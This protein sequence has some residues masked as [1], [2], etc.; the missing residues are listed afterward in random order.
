MVFVSITNININEGG[1]RML[2]LLPRS[3][4]T[5]PYHTMDR[6]NKRERRP[7]SGVGRILSCL[8]DSMSGADE[9]P[10]M[11]F[12]NSVVCGSEA[13][14]RLANTI[15]DDA[16]VFSGRRTIDAGKRVGLSEKTTTRLWRSGEQRCNMSSQG[17]AIET[18]RT[19]LN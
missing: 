16:A 17:V 19:K 14:S 9:Y 13:S 1:V 18:T 8:P 15:D 10:I 3:G 4:F 5:I 2:Q 12:D 11:N 7:N 6:A